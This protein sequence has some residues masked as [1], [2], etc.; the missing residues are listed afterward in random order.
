VGTGSVAA[1]S[2]IY[3]DTHAAIFLH[4]G[5]LELL[6]TEGK[7]VIEANDLLICP[8][9]L[10]EFNYLYEKQKIRY[11][12]RSIYTALNATFG[13]TLCAL[14]FADVAHQALDLTWTRDAFDRMIVAQ[15]QVN[16]NSVLITRDRIMH[17]NYREC[18][19]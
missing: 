11:D 4:A 5:A 8:M 19:W 16:H 6:G 17:L 1:L 15:A 12:A 10:L 9:V 7:R 18:V 2:S 3:L 13:V 14:P